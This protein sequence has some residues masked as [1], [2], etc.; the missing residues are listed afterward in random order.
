MV[1]EINMLLLRLSLSEVEISG[2]HTRYIYFHTYFACYV[3]LAGVS[4]YNE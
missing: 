1:L 4:R 3:K 2:G